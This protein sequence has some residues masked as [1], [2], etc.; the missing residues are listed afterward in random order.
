MLSGVALFGQITKFPPELIWWIQETQKVNRD[1]ELSKFI[2]TDYVEIVILNR[3]VNRER[4]YPVFMRWNFSASRFAYCHIGTELLKEKNGMYRILYDVDSAVQIIDNK[5]NLLFEEYYGS[6]SGIDEVAWL[7]D[8]EIVG[9]GSNIGNDAKGNISVSLIIKSYQIK[10]DK[11]SVT[12]Y[13]YKN[14]FSN[15]ERQNIKMKW[16]EQRSDYF[17]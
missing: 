3:N 1:I 8:D 6:S 16:E 5:N 13:V 10:L 17:N 4:Y 12:T 11:V 7:R 15:D 14:A 9:V 2:K